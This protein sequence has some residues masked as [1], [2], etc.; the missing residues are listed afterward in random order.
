MAK[1]G[2]FDNP[3][4]R[5][6]WS[7]HV[8]AWQRS[9]LSRR[10][11]CRI[12]KLTVKTFARWLGVLTDEKT[13]QIRL[14]R[15]AAERRAK[16]NRKGGKLTTD[17]RNRAAQAYWAMHVEAL[18]WSGMT[19]REYAA[20][21][22]ISQHSLRRWRDLLTNLETPVDWR[23]RLHPSARPQISSAA[24]P[25]TKGGLSPNF[26]VSD[27]GL[28]LTGGT[29]P[30]PKGESRV[31]RRRFSDDEKRELVMQ[32]LDPHVTVSQVARRHGIA[33]S[34]LFRW[35]V[36]LGLG[37]SEQPRFVTVRVQENVR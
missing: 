6:W 19:V 18:E 30:E 2:H 20:A 7:V 27:A 24:S 13:A 37:A 31:M 16:R 36:Q 35:R 14:E 21:L 17:R 5:K 15:T 34:L 11:Y 10:R 22:A 25:R 1:V 4:R 29:L 3:A 8:E 28:G 26:I 23:G 9:G 32:T 12:H 33:A